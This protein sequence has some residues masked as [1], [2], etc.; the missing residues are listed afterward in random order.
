M[1]HTQ[2]T[3][4]ARGNRTTDQQRVPVE[5]EKVFSSLV[6]LWPLKA[7]TGTTTKTNVRAIRTNYT[8]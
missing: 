6:I 1:L 8:L 4:N 7:G 2:Q 3:P 5:F